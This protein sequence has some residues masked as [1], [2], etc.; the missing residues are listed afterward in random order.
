MAVY[1]PR[2]NVCRVKRKEKRTAHKAPTVCV[3]PCPVVCVSVEKGLFV[4]LLFSGGV[5]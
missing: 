1:C 2:S 3:G 4:L 5:H